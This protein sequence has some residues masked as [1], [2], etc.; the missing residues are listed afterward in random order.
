MET[1]FKRTIGRG[2]VA[3]KSSLKEKAFP[4]QERKQAAAAADMVTP[5]GRAAY[6]MCS[7]VALSCGA[8]RYNQSCTL[9]ARCLFGP[10]V[11]LYRDF[12]PIRSSHSSTFTVHEHNKMERRIVV[13]DHNTLGT[14]HYCACSFHLSRGMQSTDSLTEKLGLP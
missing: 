13:E 4:R 11:T 5:L 7:P 10:D 6:C 8:V 9:R 3:F 12:D 1:Q 2:Q 14:A